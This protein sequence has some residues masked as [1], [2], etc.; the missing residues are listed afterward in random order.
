MRGVPLL[1]LLATGGCAYYNGIYNARAAERAAD[2]AA[3][4]GQESAAV[5]AYATVAAKAETVLVR[6]GKSRWRTEALYLAGRG[7]ALSGQCDPAMVRLTEYLG[8]DAV[9][10]RKRD[11]ATIAMGRC[12]VHRAQHSEARDLLDP[13]ASSPDPDVA[14]SAS[15]WA[16]RAAM[17]LGLNET[18]LEYL[19]T[20]DAASAQWEVI[21]SSL[22]GMEYARAES[23]LVR[24][25]ARSDY[26]DEVIPFLAQLWRAGRDSSVQRLVDDY[27][28]AKLPGRTKAAL[29]IAL[30]GL[31]IQ[32]D[33]D[34]AARRT[35]LQARRFSTDTTLDRQAGAMLALLSLRDLEEVADVE[36]VVKRARSEAPGPLV[37][38]LEGHLELLK[39]LLQTTDYTGASLFLAAEVAR[40]SLRAPRLAHTLFT[41]LAATGANSP[42]AP[43]ALLAAGAL[44]PESTAVYRARVLDSFPDSEFAYVL[45]GDDPAHLRV[46]QRTDVLLSRAWKTAV[47]S[48]RKRRQATASGG[49]PPPPP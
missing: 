43:K 28:R 1:F 39:F 37:T 27:G 4:A 41:R 7:L 31:L 19:R 47:D 35:L 5:A 32:S 14:A 30:A 34:S 49:A 12:L 44:M 10:P 46:Y 45:R 20:A 24:R 9:P 40:D 21:R 42:M 13:L 17:G 25:A 16:A 22:R 36:A 33:R 23:L 11:R 29:H 3:R 6:H 38:S 18:A 26:R 8:L 2:R 15:L 48:L